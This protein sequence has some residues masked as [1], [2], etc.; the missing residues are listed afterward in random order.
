MWR[1]L[2]V[3]AVL[4]ATRTASAAPKPCG[5]LMQYATPDGFADILVC[6]GVRHRGISVQV[7]KAGE[8]LGVYWTEHQGDKE[9]N[10]Q[11]HADGTLAFVVVDNGIKSPRFS[12]KARTTMYQVMPRGRAMWIDSVKDGLVIH[13]GGG[14]R[15]HLIETPIDEMYTSYR[16]AH[17]ERTVQATRPID[18]TEAGLAGVDLAAAK[19]FFLQHRQP[20]F[21]GYSDRTTRAYREMTSVFHDEAGGTC[22]VANAKVMVPNPSDPK[23]KTDM[24]FRFTDDA[25]LDAFLADQC[26]K[27]DRS[28]L[29]SPLD[30][31]Q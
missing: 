3:F 29:R 27:L 16:V 2:A 14:H 20:S 26:P 30:Q 31:R 19:I 5:Y 23:D 6:D 12:A 8:L 17:I 4:F 24:T 18:F 25:A 10:Y 7:T 11:L 15:W 9:R 22:S 21:G 28:P 1:P 13:D